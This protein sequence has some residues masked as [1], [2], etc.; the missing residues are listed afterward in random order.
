MAESSIRNYNYHKG[1]IIIKKGICYI[2]GASKEAAE[3]VF[4]KREDADLVIA[5]DGGYD[6]LKKHNISADILLGDFDSIDNLPEHTNIMKYP[7]KKDDT[8]TFLAF[9]A[10]FEYG[11]KNFLIFGGTGG[12]FDHTFANIQ[13]LGNIANNGGRG[14]LIG[15][16]CIMTAICNSSITFPKDS[17]GFAGVF[18]LG[19]NAKNVHIKGMKYTASNI[20]LTPYTPL[21]VSNEFTHEN[22]QISVGDGILLIIWHENTERFMSHVNSLLI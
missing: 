12:R 10:G 14:F 22:A 16:G 7:V 20:N 3:E 19:E 13:L 15:D 18:A 6:A 11:Y 1:L 4:F 17:A 5:A 21:G 9:K 2:V 8:D